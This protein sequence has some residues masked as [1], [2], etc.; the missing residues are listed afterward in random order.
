MEVTVASSVALSLVFISIVV[1][2]ACSIM[3]WVWFKPKKLETCLREQGF[4]GN[5]YKVFV[6]RHEGELYPDTNKQNPKPMNLST[7]HDIAPRVTPLLDKIVKTYG[8]NSFVWI[9]PIPRV[10][11]VESRRF[12]RCLASYEGE[13]WAKHRRIINPTFHLEKLKCMLPAFYESCNEMIKD[14]ESLVSKES[15]SSSNMCNESDSKCLH[16]RMEVSTT[17]MNKRMKEIDKE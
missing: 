4:K 15:L 1:R 2:W 13:K 7:S 9:G 14:W 11:I 16:S 10:N 6:R 3:D 17:K 8:K 5:S 12:E